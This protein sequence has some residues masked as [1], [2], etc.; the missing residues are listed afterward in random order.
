MKTGTL[1]FILL[2]LVAVFYERRQLF[3]RMRRFY[4]RRCTGR[5]WLKQF[6][7]AQKAEIREFLEVFVVAFALDA[8]KRLSFAPDDKIIDVYRTLYP[9]GWRADALEHVEWNQ[10]CKQRYRVDLSTYFHDDTTLGDLFR[11]VQNRV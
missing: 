8:K 5:A 2:A 11:V 10:A 4:D 7:S 1:I 3:K 6:P 9:E